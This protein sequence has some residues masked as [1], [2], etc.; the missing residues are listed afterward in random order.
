MPDF[1]VVA[2]FAYLIER[3]PLMEGDDSEADSAAGGFV[4]GPDTVCGGC[5]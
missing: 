1:P 4:C 5:R 2:I 3:Q